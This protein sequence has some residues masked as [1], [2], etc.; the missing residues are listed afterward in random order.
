VKEQYYFY[1]KGVMENQASK[2]NLKP[3]AKP[4]RMFPYPSSLLIDCSDPAEF[5]LRVRQWLE[6]YAPQ[7]YSAGHK[8]CPGC[9]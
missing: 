8:D 5:Q 9:R 6:G 3:K 4:Q 7:G 2:S 1:G